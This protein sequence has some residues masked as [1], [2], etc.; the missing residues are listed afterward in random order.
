MLLL[1]RAKL[2]LNLSLVL[3]KLAKWHAGLEHF[4]NFGRCATR[5]LGKNEPADNADDCTGAPKAV[6]S[7]S[8]T[9]LT[10]SPS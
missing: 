2:P 1:L 8:N 5:D 3:C 4:I 6:V 9:S 10:R 7:E